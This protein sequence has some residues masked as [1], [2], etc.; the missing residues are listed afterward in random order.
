M[1]ALQRLKVI[2]A[3]TIRRIASVLLGFVLLLFASTLSGQAQQ[4][5]EIGPRHAILIGNASYSGIPA[6]RNPINDV[7]SLAGA[8]AELG[9]EIHLLEDATLEGKRQ[10]LADTKAALPQGATVFFYYAGHA[11][12]V[13]GLNWLIP[14]DFTVPDDLNVTQVTIGI[15][16]ILHLLDEAGADLKI[17]V[18]DACRD[19]PLGNVEDVFG[20]GLAD[21]AATGETLIAYATTA[22]AVASDGRGPNSPFAGALVSALSQEGLELYDIFRQVR[23]HVREATNGQQLPWVSGSIESSVVLHAASEPPADRPSG[24]ALEP[25][26]AVHWQAI[27]SSVNP[28][29]FLQFASLHIGTAASEVAV[30]RAAFLV[31][32]G[33]TLVPRIEIQAVQP[34]N[35]AYVVTACDVWASDPDDPDRVAPG[36]AWGLINIR[37]AIRDCSIALAEDPDNPR[38]NYHLGRALSEANRYEDAVRFYTRSVELGYPIAHVSL[39]ILYRN[40]F[41][42][43]VDETRTAELWM[44]AAEQGVQ[45]A[46]VGLAK[47]YEEGWGVEQ[48]FPE[49]LRLLETLEAQNYARALDHLGNVYRQPI[50]VEQDYDRARLLYERAALQGLSNATSNLARM[51]RDGL[52]V[53]PDWE[54]AV[55]IY[56][57]AVEQGNPFAPHH[58]AGMLVNPPEGVMRDTDTAQ[59]L[60][61]LSL[62]R[63]LA[64]AAFRLG[65]YWDRGVFGEED[66]A[67]AAYYLRIAEAAGAALRFDDGETLQTAAASLLA[68]VEQDLTPQEAAAAELRARTWIETN[69]VFGFSNI[70]RY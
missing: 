11:L 62:E 20:D 14:T 10:F 3:C 16:E 39:G 67:E 8:L 30:Q 54:R 48:S 60:L 33:Q 42:V 36:I 43:E 29:D 70:Y 15:D 50:F 21:V 23:S 19:Y 7:R 41:G 27:E 38:L 57:Q 68:E 65:Q 51:Y 12:Q 69:G 47:L 4:S 31:Q 61:E 64:W 35:G 24:E 13:N 37:E 28:N 1:V 34:A 66:Q 63:G 2:Q 56:S 46:Q 40:G 18:L 53:E 6:L 26:Q 58:L 5:D 17:V 55:Q 52:G 44:T 9:F 49:M 45:L 59:A 22:G 25:V 32:E